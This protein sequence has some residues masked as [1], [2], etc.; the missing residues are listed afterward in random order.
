MNE[1][2]RNSLFAVDQ[3]LALVDVWVAAF[4]GVP[5]AERNRRNGVVV[6]RGGN[7][8]L[9]VGKRCAGS[10]E[11]APSWGEPTGKQ[12]RDQDVITL[13]SGL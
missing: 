2:P 4:D 6:F 12:Q 13:H 9:L 3:F 1:E 11:G 10:V 5:D 8:R 7:G